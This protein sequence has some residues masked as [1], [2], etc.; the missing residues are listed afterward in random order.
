MQ[1]KS[2]TFNLER[3]RE[4]EMRCVQWGSESGNQI[5]D[6]EWP[7]VKWTEIFSDVWSS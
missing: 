2:G 1:R 7:L 5:I 3:E 4:R 6:H